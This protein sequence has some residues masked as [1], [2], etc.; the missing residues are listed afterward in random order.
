MR[1]WV[2]MIL[3]L[4]APLMLSVINL[5]SFLNKGVRVSSAFIHTLYRYT[6]TKKLL[7]KDKYRDRKT[8]I[9]E[10]V[11]WSGYPIVKKNKKKDEGEG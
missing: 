7:S 5:S 10:R 6:T 8:L 1:A 4:L 3:P 2:C 9:N 11:S